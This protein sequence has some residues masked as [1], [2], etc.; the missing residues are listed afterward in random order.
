MISGSLS[1]YNIQISRYLLEVLKEYGG[2]QE[3]FSKLYDI[4]M[5]DGLENWKS[6]MVKL[7]R[8]VCYYAF[9]RRCFYILFICFYNFLEGEKT[10]LLQLKNI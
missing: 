8:D 2:R 6:F 1:Y 9:E 7:L 4:I 3:P 5:V 10:K